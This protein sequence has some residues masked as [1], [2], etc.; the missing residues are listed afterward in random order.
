MAELTHFDDKGRAR[1]VDVGSKTIT[2]RQAIVRGRV[3]M[4]PRTF[5]M[6][7]DRTIAKGDVLGVA[8]I[9]GIMAAKR[10]AELIP[11]C[12]PLALTS[13]EIDF[14]PLPDESTIEIEARVRTEGKTGVE[15][16]AFVG[17]A[18]AAITIY[19]MCKAVDRAIVIADIHLVEKKGGK[20]GT[21]VNP[22]RTSQE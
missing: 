8:R 13:V 5:Q 14:F 10:T 12:H 2:S 16:D 20:S 22:R 19:D 9:A 7:L 15:I 4:A 6:I 18:T 1:M 17:V 11:L 21:Y 3:S